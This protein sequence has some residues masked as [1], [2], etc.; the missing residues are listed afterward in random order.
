MGHIY[1]SVYQVNRENNFFTKK[2]LEHLNPPKEFDGFLLWAIW[3]D[4][5]SGDS[6]KPPLHSGCVLSVNE[7][8]C[9]AKQYGLE[10]QL[11]FRNTHLWNRYI[12]ERQN[13]NQVHPVISAFITNKKGI[14]YV[15]WDSFIDYLIDAPLSF[16]LKNADKSAVIE[17]I[18][19]LHKKYVDEVLK[20]K[21]EDGGF[22]IYNHSIGYFV[23]AEFLGNSY[24]SK[25]YHSHIRRREAKRKDSTVGGGDGDIEIV[26]FLYSS[27]H[28]G[29]KIVKWYRHR[30]V[31]Q[32]ERFI[33][34][35]KLAFVGRAYM[36]KGWQNFIVHTCRLEK[37]ELFENGFIYSKCIHDFFLTE[38]KLKETINSEGMKSFFKKN[39]FDGFDGF[40]S[41]IAF[42]TEDACWAM[43]ILKIKKGTALSESII[44]KAFVAMAFKHHPDRGGEAEQFIKCE[45]AR[46]FLL[47][48]L[49]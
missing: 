27:Y 42:D 46:E 8:Q 32:T 36:K 47:D 45:A 24:N 6:F 29:G 14:Q 35:E 31:K 30:I 9:I 18:A 40:E 5:P 10:T 17:R 26:T 43:N 13:K 39:T 49:N 28:Y 19:S 25:Y 34:V 16:E 1:L 37:K 21:R 44:K 22:L 4:M 41:V 23:N 11:H 2:Q 3:D 20:Y 7:M 12:I 33:Y 38:E 15:E 48:Q